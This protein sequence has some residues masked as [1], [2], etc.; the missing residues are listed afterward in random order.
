M[1]GARREMP[2]GRGRYAAVKVIPRGC[3]GF[4]PRRRCLAAQW[5]QTSTLCAHWAGTSA[6]TPDRR[7]AADTIHHAAAPDLLVCTQNAANATKTA[8]SRIREWIHLE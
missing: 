7:D 1:P 8:A 2:V 4:T 6:R 5:S 3:T